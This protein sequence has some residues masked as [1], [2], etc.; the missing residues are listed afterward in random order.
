M[1]D[2]NMDDRFQLD[3]NGFLKAFTRSLDSVLRK[4]VPPR[5]HTRSL[6][7]EL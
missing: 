7:A 3:F 1:T 2:F 4:A 5:M 6:R